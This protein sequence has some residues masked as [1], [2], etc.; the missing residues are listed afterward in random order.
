VKMP[1]PRYRFFIKI[2]LWFWLAT[3]IMMETMGAIHRATMRPRPNFEGLGNVFGS[4]YSAYGQSSLD[5]LEA[6]GY[7]A[8]EDYFRY[9]KETTGIDFYVFDDK[10]NELAGR[11]SPDGIE[12]AVFLAGISRKYEVSFTP[13][14]LFSA[15]YIS[16][17]DGQGYVIAGVSP[18]P[19]PRP[20]RERPSALII[21]L[22]VLIPLSG[23]GCY[24]LALYVTSPLIKLSHAVRQFAAGNHAVRVSAEV[25]TGK[26]EISELARDFD[27]MAARIESLISSQR[28]LLRDISHEL[29]SPLA[30]LNVALELCRRRGDTEYGK[31][32]DRI[33]RESERLNELIGQ[34]MTLTRYESGAPRPDRTGIA[35]APLIRQIVDD[36][37]FEAGGS[38]RTVKLASCEECTVTGSEETL[39]RAVENVVRNA[40]RYTPEGSDVEV[41]LRRE[42]EGNESQ[43]SITVRDHG[44]GAPEDKLPHLFKPFFR[45]D[46]A[47][48]RE[49]GG[50]GLGLAIT[51]AAVRFHGGVVTASN[52]PGGGLL[53]EIRLPLS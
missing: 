27:S 36:A 5:I 33:E 22:L 28:N 17:R 9:L 1:M 10:G 16:G 39:R 3:I 13:A 26:D 34:T 19:P 49:T 38:N 2:F 48:D 42:R 45:V 11:K 6:G 52:A 31:Y 47:R 35:L 4:A 8:L 41:S 21:R 7:F 15:Q 43:A 46:D 18:G 12:R 20:F 51:E 40:I 29:R 37:D 14:G 53:V 24:W 32:L 23:A 30:R 25:G 50:V 44:P